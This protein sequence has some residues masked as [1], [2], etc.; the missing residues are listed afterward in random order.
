MNIDLYWRQAIIAVVTVAA[1]VVVAL[2]A[3]NLSPETLATLVGLITAAASQMPPATSN[4][5]TS[6]SKPPP[7]M[8]DGE[9]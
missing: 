3:K 1:V 2:N 5:K 4:A 6:I 9:E 8:K 7:P